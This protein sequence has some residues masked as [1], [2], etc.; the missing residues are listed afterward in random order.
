MKLGS[1]EIAGN[2]SFSIHFCILKAFKEGT[3]LYK[4]GHFAKGA[5]APCAPPVPTSMTVH[6][7]LDM[8]CSWRVF[9]DHM[10]DFR[11]N[12]RLDLSSMRPLCDL[13]LDIASDSIVV[14]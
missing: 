10:E 7:P 3:K 9:Q 13:A 4:K 8:T 2:A 14:E 5:R 11:S 12:N 1:S 6:T